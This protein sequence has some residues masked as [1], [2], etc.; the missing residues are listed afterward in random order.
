[1]AVVL[2]ANLLVVLATDEARAKTI[3]DRFGEWAEAG[4]ELH[5]P[6]LMLYE[7]ANALTRLI[8][9]GQL[10]AAALP[11]AWAAIERTPITYHPLRD[12]PA[13]VELALRLGGQSAYWAPLVRARVHESRQSEGG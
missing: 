12:G 3:A 11:Q 13:A 2:D 5:A 8:A 10:A 6:A 1:M 9:R 7:A 4:E